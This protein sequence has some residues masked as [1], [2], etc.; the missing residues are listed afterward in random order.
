M[1]DYSLEICTLFAQKFPGSIASRGGRRLR[2]GDW[3]L[4]FPETSGDYQAKEAFLDSVEHL[5]EIKL[6]EAVW[7]RF[8]AHEELTALYLIDDSTLYQYLGRIH[9]EKIKKT[10]L[11][12]LSQPPLSSNIAETVRGLFLDLLEQQSRLV[13]DTLLVDTQEELLALVN[14]IRDLLTLCELPESERTAYTIRQL[15]IQ[16]FHNS[17]RIEH[18]LQFGNHCLVKSLQS[19]LH[20]LLKLSRIYPETTCMLPGSLQFKSGAEWNLEGKSVTLPFSTIS[21]IVRYKPKYEGEQLLVLENKEN[22]HTAC[23]R[24]KNPSKGSPIRLFSGFF[25]VGGYPNTAD[26]QL[27]RILSNSGIKISYFCD[28]DP[29]GLLIAQ[30]VLALCEGKAAAYHMD[31]ETYHTYEEY[32]YELTTSELGKLR[33]VDAPELVPLANLISETGKGIEQEIMSID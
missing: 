23:N 16:L 33:G 21:E 24:L 8:R 17:K 4:R 9:P 30:K 32:G 5:C 26:E 27:L 12:E 18:L 25:Y 1:K 15:S 6:V 28:L 11:A 29:S 14:K 22:F 13:A 3:N 31:P 2:L 7:K 10:L 20:E 19:S